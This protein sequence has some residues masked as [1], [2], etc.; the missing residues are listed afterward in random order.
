MKKV[1]LLAAAALAL[2]SCKD[3]I[4]PVET[5]DSV[6]LNVYE[7]TVATEGASFNV[8]VSSSKDW[9][10]TPAED[11]DWVVASATKGS[12]GDIVKFTVAAN[13]GREDKT[14]K[15][16]FAVGEDSKELTIISL[17]TPLMKIEAE[18][19]EYIVDYN[20][21]EVAVNIK[22]EVEN[23]RDIK[24]KV[25]GEWL[26]YVVTLPGTD[27]F[28]A[29]AKFSYD[30]L[31]GLEDHSAVITF[32]AEG[33][34]DCD[35]TVIQEAK[36]VI[37]VEKEFFTLAVEGQTL[38]VPVTS[39]V[40]YSMTVSEGVNSWF[41]AEKTATGIKVT[42]T[43]LSGDKRSAT[44]TLTQTDAKQGVEPIVR[45]VNFTQVPVLINWAAKMTGNRLFPKWDG[46]AAKLGVAHA[47][48]LE[49]ML[50]VS[51]FH[52]E[53]NTI[54][55]IEGRFLLRFGDA[56]I[57]PNQLQVAT[58]N[59]NY[60]VDYNF[61]TNKWYHIAC[62]Y[63]MDDSYNATVKVYVDGA[64]VG[65]KS[66][67]SMRVYVG[68]PT[69]GY[70]SGVDFS[71]AWS[72][73]PDGTRCFWLGYAYDANRDLRGLMTEIRIWNKVLTAEEIN[74]PDHFYTVDPKSEGLYAYWKMTAGEGSSIEDATGNGN[75]LYGETNVRKQGNDNKGD[76]G[77][78]W[79]SV[80]LPDK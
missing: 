53:I 63:E 78:E 51:E 9:T 29:S 75:K 11:Y 46:T 38:E 76:E 50:N 39:N 54:M 21:G 32:S 49:T 72:Y 16:N 36:D 45:V 33:A 18:K 80:A 52:K 40:E 22:T 60:L 13:T 7:K 41:T 55:G 14:A 23:Y 59:G 67:W 28:D 25:D 10:L 30:A 44:V 74:A 68:W 3:D 31:P 48:T 66:N 2:F 43:P 15:F 19:T 65:E 6:E 57:S 5:P 24:V 35:V 12:D 73:E 61:E 62:T 71:P 4:K 20:K 27:G 1:L 26:S 17:C 37:D 64:L 58:L 42:A 70:V 47:I 69:W 56:G 34:A 8:I 77:I 79:V